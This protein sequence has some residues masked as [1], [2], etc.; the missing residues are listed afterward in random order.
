MN[1]LTRYYIYRSSIDLG[2]YRISIPLAKVFSD[3]FINI[4]QNII[5]T[6]IFSEN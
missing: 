6:D 2:Y 4:Y 5:V 3:N 1:K